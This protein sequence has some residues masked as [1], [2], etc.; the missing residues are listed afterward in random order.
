MEDPFRQ[1]IEG[2]PVLI[3]RAGPDGFCDYFNRT[4]L[5]FTGRAMEQ[6]LGRGWAEGIHDEDRERC[7]ATFE[8]ALE[9]GLGFTIEYR[10]RRHDGA[11]RWIVDNGAPFE[12]AGGGFAGLMGCGIDIHDGR[13]GRDELTRALEAQRLALREKDQAL[14]DKEVLLAELQHRVRNTVQMIISMLSVQAHQAASGE[15][16]ELLTRSAARVRSLGQVQER[17]FRRTA[18]GSIELGAYLDELVRDLVGAAERPELQVLTD[19]QPLLVPTGLAAPLGFIVSELV[20]NALQHAFPAGKAGRLRLALALRPDGEAELEV[21]DDGCGLA[22]GS[23]PPPRPAGNRIGLTL[24]GALARQARATVSVES[25]GG[26]RF[27]LRFP[28]A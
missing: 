7:L 11:W 12:D 1:L 2:A 25:D 20:G 13:T 24:L 4:W 28:A 22:P 18:P 23:W 9:Q 14:R 26:T 17:L 19:L 27:R 16:A 8:R 5:E 21:A 6:E 3:R 15:A 10:L